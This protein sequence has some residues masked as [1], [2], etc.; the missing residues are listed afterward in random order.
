MADFGVLPLWFIGNL[1]FLHK[2]KPYVFR[3]P[4]SSVALVFSFWGILF[5]V[6]TL[7]TGEQVRKFHSRKS[8]AMFPPNPSNFIQFHPRCLWTEIWLR[9]LQQPSWAW[10]WAR[11][12]DLVGPCWSL[13]VLL[14]EAPCRAARVGAVVQP[15]NSCAQLR[16]CA[17]AVESDSVSL[18]LGP[19]TKNGSVWKWGIHGYCMVL[20]YRLS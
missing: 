10:T 2:H 5:L 13:L 3:Y 17:A 15:V 12:L 9:L 6:S 1:Y 7:Q 18:K 16:I 19:S 4:N 20:P 8:H 11:L 14:K